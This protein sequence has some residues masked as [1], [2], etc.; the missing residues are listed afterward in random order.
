MTLSRRFVAA[1]SCR[2]RPSPAACTR[3]IADTERITAQLDD[4]VTGSHILPEPKDRELA[5]G[6]AMQEEIAEA[7]F[8]A[9]ESPLYGAEKIRAQRKPPDGMDPWDLVMRALSH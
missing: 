5:D 7:R 8:P 1:G 2:T 3:C 6:F 9:M 4:L